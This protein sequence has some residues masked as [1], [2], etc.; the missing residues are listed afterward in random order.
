MRGEKNQIFNTKKS[1]TDCSLE[2]IEFKSDAKMN[3][4]HAGLGSGINFSTNLDGSQI[5]QEFTK[6]KVYARVGWARGS[7]GVILAPPPDQWCPRRDS[8]Y[9]N[10]S[11]NFSC[12]FL[13]PNNFFQFEL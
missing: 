13:N 8:K 1:L 7:N 12:R 5:D 4:D 2:A 6:G 3:Y 9:Y 11:F 10:L